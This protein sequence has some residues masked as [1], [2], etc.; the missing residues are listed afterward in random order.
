VAKLSRDTEVLMKE[1]ALEGVRILDLSEGIAGP[2]CTR[3]LGGYGADVVKVEKPGE[4]DRSRK[5]GPFPQ[6]IPHPHR[7][8]PTPKG[9]RFSFT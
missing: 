9:V 4:G 2:Y 6:D 3:L 5:V 7:T 8:F 1:R